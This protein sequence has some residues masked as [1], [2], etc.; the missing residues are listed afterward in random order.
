MLKK[1]AVFR[2]TKEARYIFEAIKEALETTP[3]LVNRTD[4]SKDFTL[5]AFGSM[6]LIFA[7]LVQKNNDGLEQLI[8]FFSQGL[9][10]YQ[11]KYKPLISN[12]KIHFMVAHPSVKEFPLSKDL[13]EK[14]VGWII[15]VME[16]D[17]DIKTTKLIRAK[18]LCEQ[19]A[20]SPENK[21]KSESKTI[22]VNDNGFHNAVPRLHASWVQ[23]MTHFLQTD[24]FPAGLGRAKRRYFRLQS[25]PYVLI[26]NIIFRKDLNGVLLRCIDNDQTKKMLH[27]FHDETAGGHF[28]PQQHGK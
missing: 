4:F 21:Q 13:D 6:N 14:R 8:A 5:Y 20:S 12:N 18:G 17:V 9:A 7:M 28:T 11:K 23:D 19:L 22:L 1:N 3:T 16:F 25:I 15:R 27:E 26:D 24:E 10:D 2:W